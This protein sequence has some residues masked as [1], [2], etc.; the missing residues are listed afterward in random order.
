MYKTLIFTT[1]CVQCD[2]DLTLL[3]NSEISNQSAVPFLIDNQG[4]GKVRLVIFNST[5]RFIYSY[6]FITN[7]YN[8]K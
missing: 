8:V 6:D 4:N 5:G 1:N 2:N 7:S 3:A